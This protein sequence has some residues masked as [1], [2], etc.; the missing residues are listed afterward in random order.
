MIQSTEFF[1][2]VK[3]CYLTG[4]QDSDPIGFI[5]SSYILKHRSLPQT[6]LM[7]NIYLQMKRN[8]QNNKAISHSQ[9]IIKFPLAYCSFLLI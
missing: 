5:L 6:M 3:S 1:L 7:L 4:Y 2:K 8:N 9:D